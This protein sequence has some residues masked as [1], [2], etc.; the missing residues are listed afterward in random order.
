MPD[1]ADEIADAVGVRIGSP[2]YVNQRFH[3]AFE[4]PLRVL[5][6]DEVIAPSFR[7]ESEQLREIASKLVGSPIDIEHL[8]VRTYAQYKCAAKLASKE[9]MP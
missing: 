3:L 9:Q 4:G 2:S 7:Q 1:R 5:A 6:D 8:I